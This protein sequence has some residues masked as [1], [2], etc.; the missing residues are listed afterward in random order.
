MK[1]GARNVLKGR[2]VEAT[3]SATAAIIAPIRRA[4]GKPGAGA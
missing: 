4:L 1:V 2:I 3:K